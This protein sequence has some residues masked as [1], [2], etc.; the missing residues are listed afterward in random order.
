[1][2]IAFD[3]HRFK[4]A[5]Q[6]YVQGRLDYPQELIERVVSLTGLHRHH[7]VLDLG[8]GPGFLAAA[9]ALH[10]DDVVGIDPEPAMLEQA[11]VYAAER[12]AAVKLVQGSSYELGNHL[13]RFRL[14][15]MGRAFHWMD[16]SATLDALARIVEDDGVVAEG[17]GF[18]SY[19]GGYG[20]IFIGW[21][22]RRRSPAAVA[23]SG[24]G[25]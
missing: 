14:V 19:E 6:H 17:V 3:A 5:A 18:T 20:V 16:R 11:V 4:T 7:R 25:S 23:R 1:M 10:V 22:G 2:P 9:F 8:C 15:T 21:T 24:T 13:G 12:G